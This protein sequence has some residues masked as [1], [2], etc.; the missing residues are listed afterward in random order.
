[1]NSHNMSYMNKNHDVFHGFTFIQIK[2]MLIK[3]ISL[4]MY[5]NFFFNN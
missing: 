2:Q 5:F 3:K 4:L 1:M